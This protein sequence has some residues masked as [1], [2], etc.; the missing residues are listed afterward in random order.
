VDLRDHTRATGAHLN[1]GVPNA[2]LSAGVRRAHPTAGLRNAHLTAGVR[3]GGV[4]PIR[5]KL[6]SHLMVI[7]AKTV[8]I[9][10]SGLYEFQGCLT[11]A[12]L[13]TKYFG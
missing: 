2:R 13:L 11:L 7:V 10:H 4:Y 6:S 8:S 1:A 9:R 3:R 5:I 12:L